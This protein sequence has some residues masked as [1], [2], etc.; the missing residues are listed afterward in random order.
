M[1]KNIKKNSLIKKSISKLKIINQIKGG[2]C[3]PP[4]TIII[5]DTEG[6]MT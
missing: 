6:D 1:K 5:K 4:P 2:C 3:K